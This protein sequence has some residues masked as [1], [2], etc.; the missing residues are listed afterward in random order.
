MRIFIIN[1][2]N[3]NMLGKRPESIYGKLTLEEI[4]KGL[5]EKANE[6]GFQAEFYQSNNE[7]ELVEVIHKAHHEAKGIIVNLAAYS[8]YSIALRDAVEILSI[9]VIEVHLSNIYSR[10]D[11]RHKSLISSLADG[12]ICGFGPLGYRLALEAMKDI[13]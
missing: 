4:N 12:V 2:P 13:L 9:P 3:L 7:G 8:H 6:L 1:G 5:S 11:F 10:E